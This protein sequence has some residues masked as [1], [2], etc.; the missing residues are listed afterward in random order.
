MNANDLPVEAIAEIEARKKLA[1]LLGTPSERKQLRQR[2][3]YSAR[4]V[5][6]LVGLSERA[7]LW[8]ESPR[9]NYSRGSLTSEAGVRYLKFLRMARDDDR[10]TTKDSG[11]ASPAKQAA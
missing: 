11:R 4:D 7:I 5:A 9:W 3:G 2:L 8:R 6:S 10:T 1:A